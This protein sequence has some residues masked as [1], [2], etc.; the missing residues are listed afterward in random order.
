MNVINMSNVKAYIPGKKFPDISITGTSCPLNCAYCEGYYLH[1]ME[2][3]PTP[4]KL[5]DTVKYLV[6][7][8]AKGVLI[9]GGFDLQGKLPVEPFLSTIKD[10]KR[11]FDIIISVHQGLVSKDLAIKLREAGVDIVDYEMILDPFVIKNI[12]NLK[13]K[14]PED[15]IRSFELLDKY[16]PPY[17]A[18]HIPLGLNYG[19]IVYEYKVIDALMDFNPYIL[20]FLIFIPTRGTK[21]ENS[22]IPEAKDVVKIIAYAR[23]KFNGILAL[24]CMRPWK[25][26]YLVDPY[27]IEKQLVDRI[28]NPPKSI[29]KKYG[30]RVIE[31]CCS[32][33]KE[34]LYKFI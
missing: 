24:G 7:R 34:L 14:D 6:K 20:V 16:G 17:I 3:A 22:S 13:N 15:Y 2:L 21:M 1:G 18:P 5:Y 25:T 27:L 23:K 11:D 12:K 30:L 19:K 33:P 10:I 9:S 31:A 28:T 4:K 26:K 32:V 8:G 29:I